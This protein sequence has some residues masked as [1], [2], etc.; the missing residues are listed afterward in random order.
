MFIVSGGGTGGHQFP[1]IAIATACRERWPEKTVLLVGRDTDGERQAA[2]AAELEFMG[3]TV[4]PIRRRLS[5]HNLKALLRLQRSTR[6]VAQ[7]MRDQ[8]GLVVTTGGYVSGPAALAAR[9]RGWP[10]V[11]HE[12]NSY[13]GMVTRFGSRWAHTICTTFES[14]HVHL[15]A[16]RCL[17]TGLPVRPSVTPKSEWC[18]TVPPLADCPPRLLILGGS[19][20]SKALV[21]SAGPVLHE[22]CS[23]TPPRCTALLQT[24]E[25]NRALVEGPDDQGPLQVRAFVDDVGEAYREADLI[26]C[27]AGAGTLA[28]VSLWGLPAVLVPYP[29]AAGDHQRRNAEDYVQAGAAEQLDEDDLTPERLRETLLRLFDEPETRQRMSEA[30]TRLARPAALEAILNV[31]A[32]VREEASC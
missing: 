32:S 18:R 22:L 1:A 8:T 3:L 7:R 31:L 25:R 16:K 26:L 28:E 9:R 14:S 24:G 13:P 4:D 17:L 15:L 6:R 21:E 27:R 19:Q 20:G 12:Q 2:E 11:M 29:Y 30:M 5:V 23:Q 10:L